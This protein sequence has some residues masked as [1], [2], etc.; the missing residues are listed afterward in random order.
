M[1]PS[2]FSIAYEVAAEV[3]E[4]LRGAFERFMTE[5]HIPDLM[6][7]GCFRKAHFETSAPGKYRTR[8]EAHDRA[9]LEI[10][11]ERHAIRLRAHVAETFPEGITFER[12]E[13]ET[14]ASFE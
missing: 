5:R 10:Y 3:P 1:S 8:Y 11:M 4:D 9:S 6:A 7:T 12:K 2:N 13:W 14:L